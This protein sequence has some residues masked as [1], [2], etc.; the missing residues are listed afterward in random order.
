ME[1]GLTKNMAHTS[2]AL[3]WAKMLRERIQTPW[4]K[5]RLLLDMLVKHLTIFSELMNYLPLTLASQK[6]LLTYGYSSTVST[7]KP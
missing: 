4:E 7:V 6:D 3:K 2:G 5:I 1:N